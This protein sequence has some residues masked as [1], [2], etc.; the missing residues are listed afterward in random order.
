[1]TPSA[2]VQSAGDLSLVDDPLV[3]VLAVEQDDRVGRRGAVRGAGRD[4]LRHRLPHLGVLRLGVAVCGA[5]CGGG[6]R[7]SLRR[8]RLLGRGLE[9]QRAHQREG[10]NKKWTRSHEVTCP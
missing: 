4:D 2:T 7:R 8:R 9:R 6:L 10:E 1:M 3:E 5:A